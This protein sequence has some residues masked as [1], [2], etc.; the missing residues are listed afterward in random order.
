MRVLAH[1][2]T[3]NDAD[4]IG[5][6]LDALLRQTRRPDAILIVDNAST[7]KTLDRTFPEQVTVIRNHMNLGTSGTIRTGFSHALAH[8]FDWIWVFDA[9]S[10]PELDALEKLLDLYAGWPSEQQQE[11]GFLASLARNQIGRAHV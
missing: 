2:H 6:I 1:I 4:V 3:Y 7:D 5:Q 9:D 11:T 10:V 8:E